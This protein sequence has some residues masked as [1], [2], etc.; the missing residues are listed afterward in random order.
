VKVDQ[1]NDSGRQD[2]DRLRR[3]RVDANGARIAAPGV[4]WTIISENWDYDWFQQD[5][6]WQWRWP[7]GDAVVARGVNVGGGP[8]RW[9]GAGWATT[10]SC[11]K[12]L[13][14]A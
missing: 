14:P 3:H 11:W 10:A 2:L 4:N 7:S 9:R 1:G 6:R 5:G 13:R 12:I 8:G